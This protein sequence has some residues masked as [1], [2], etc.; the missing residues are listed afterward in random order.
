MNAPTAFFLGGLL[1][2]VCWGIWAWNHLGPEEP[3][4]VVLIAGT[5]LSA[6]AAVGVLIIVTGGPS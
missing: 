4:W 2:Q 1:F 6:V 5:I 3:N